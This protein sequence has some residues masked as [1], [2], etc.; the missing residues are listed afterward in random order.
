MGSW[1]WEKLKVACMEFL[2][3]HLK[4]Q[5]SSASTSDRGL[6]LFGFTYSISLMKWGI[7][8]Q[9]KISNIVN[10]KK[11]KV[12]EKNMSHALNCDRW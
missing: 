12:H 9:T 11:I 7:K 1:I 5:E 3:L 6:A 4:K 8:L 10:Q 2:A